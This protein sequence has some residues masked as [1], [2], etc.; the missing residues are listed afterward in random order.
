MHWQAPPPRVRLERLLLNDDAVEQPRLGASLSS[1]ISPC[2]LELGFHAASLH[3]GERVRYRHRLVGLESS[4]NERWGVGEARYRTL[5]PG[6]FSLEIQAANADGVWSPISQALRLH[7]SRPLWQ[8]PGWLAT[9]AVISAALLWACAVLVSR[10]KFK[11][12]LLAAQLEHA[13]ESERT[14]IARDLHD[15]LG[16]SLTEITLLASLGAD[17]SQ[18]AQ[19]TKEIIQSL[20]HKTRSAVGNLDEI[21]WAVNPKNDTLASFAEYAAALAVDLT[22]AAKMRL[23][24][25]IPSG[26]PA[27][28]LKTQLRHNLFLAYREAL[29]NAVKH[30]HASEVTV[31]LELLEKQLRLSITD[32]GCGFVMQEYNLSEG[33]KNLKSRLMEISGTVE[34]IS[35]PQKGTRVVLTAPLS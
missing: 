13:R 15:E 32:N 5:P 4:W 16:A 35:A 8:Q 26:L 12:R 2:S 31:R 30:S 20:E 7:V 33:L 29:N 19:A 21:V 18:D 3:S 25:D 11:K 6:E 14:R 34:F 27:K 1:G 17:A 24:L 9:L 10:R 22:E 28:L 23:R